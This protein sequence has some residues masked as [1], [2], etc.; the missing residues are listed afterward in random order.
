MNGI[1]GSIFDFNRDGDLSIF[2]KSAE[3]A[4]LAT[5]MDEEENE[6]VPVLDDLDDDERGE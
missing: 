1:F 4:F 6:D 5:I 2:E 3:I